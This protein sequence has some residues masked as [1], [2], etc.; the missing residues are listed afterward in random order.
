MQCHLFLNCPEVGD[1]S[2]LAV[3]YCGHAICRTFLERNSNCHVTLNAPAG[4]SQCGL[5]CSL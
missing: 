3:L 5:S 4:W 2:L 1:P